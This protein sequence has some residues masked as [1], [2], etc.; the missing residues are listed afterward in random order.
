MTNKRTPKISPNVEEAE[1]IEDIP[2]PNAKEPERHDLSIFG[3]SIGSYAGW[4]KGN[5]TTHVFHDYVSTIGIPDGLL[6]YDAMAGDF[7][8]Y[9]DAG[10]PTMELNIV[11]TLHRVLVERGEIPTPEAAVVVPSEPVAPVEPVE[12]ITAAAI[13]WDG[14]TYSLPKPARHG[15]VLHSVEDVLGAEKS[16]FATQGFLTSEG[17]FVNRVQAL[18]IA[19]RANQIIK[20]TGGD[21][22]LYSEDVW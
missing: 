15:Q 22:D 19:H 11:R 10:E 14:V 5:E 20:K 21:R 8:Y 6:G 18:Q 2:G 12:C 13:Q 3:I 1:V 4:S 9:N 16:A 7:R 17:R